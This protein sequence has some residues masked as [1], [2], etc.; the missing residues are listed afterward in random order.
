MNNQM[1]KLFKKEIDVSFN[2]KFSVEKNLLQEEIF[3]I[4]SND[5]LII[6]W[7]QHLEFFQIRWFIENLY[8]YNVNELLDGQIG[9]SIDSNTNKPIPSWN[10]NWLVIGY[11]SSD[12]I[13]YNLKTKKF[14][15]VFMVQG[16]GI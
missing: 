7:F 4:L 5:S 9:Y 10:K 8:L 13:I 1:I 2:I 16:T 14:I 15:V 12:P 3:K 11:A 6:E